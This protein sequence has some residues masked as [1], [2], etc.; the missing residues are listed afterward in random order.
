MTQKA[1]E[2]VLAVALIGSVSLFIASIDIYRE[3]M[4]PWKELL[5]PMLGGALIFIGLFYRALY[6]PTYKKVGTAF[7][8]FLCGAGLGNYIFL[9]MNQAFADDN[10]TTEQFVVEKQG[11]IGRREEP[12]AHIN[13][14]GLEKDLVFKTNDVDPRKKYTEVALEYSKG[15]FGYQVIDK[16]TMTE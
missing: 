1:K 11:K 7:F 14:H 16:K 6:T 2:T 13:F 8:C 3:T 12:Y 9:E 5:L 4:I 10:T 15:L